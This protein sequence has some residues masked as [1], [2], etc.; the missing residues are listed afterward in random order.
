MCPY[1]Q[2]AHFGWFQV[3]ICLICLIE[4]VCFP[5]F[6]PISSSTSSQKVTQ[7]PR[8]Y[9]IKVTHTQIW[10]IDSMLSMISLSQMRQY[11]VYYNINESTVYIIDILSEI[12]L[13]MCL[14]KWHLISVICSKVW[15]LWPWNTV[16]LAHFIYSLVCCSFSTEN[17]KCR[18]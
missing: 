6:R 2:A 13:C 16:H 4:Q 17:F 18:E 14:W 15:S 7:T 11:T 8:N 12:M 1:Q 3:Y 9:S 10:Y 5:A